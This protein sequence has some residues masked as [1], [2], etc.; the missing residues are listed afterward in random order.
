[1]DKKEAEKRIKKL[2]A[3]IARLREAYHVSD[4]P[5]VTDDVYDSL[6]RE[7]RNL[8]KKFPEFFHRGFL[9]YRVSN[10]SNPSPQFRLEPT[11]PEGTLFTYL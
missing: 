3:E 2:R 6:N 10:P 11:L 1:M 7:L 9:L 4:S 8:I 5:T